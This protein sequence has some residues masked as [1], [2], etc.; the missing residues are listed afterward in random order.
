MANIT[1]VVDLIHPA[2]DEVSVITADTIWI[3]FDR[4]MDE[5]SINTGT[6]FLQGPDSNALSGPDLHLYNENL[7]DVSNDAD[8]LNSPGFTG[9]VPGTI[10]FQK[11]NNLSLASYT[12][13]DYSG[14]GTLW[15]T[16]AVFTP[17]DSLAP[18][19][20]YTVYLA[21]DEDTSADPETGIRERTVFDTQKGTNTG[22]GEASFS[23]GYIGLVTS[24]TFNIEFTTAGTRGVARFKWWKTSDPDILY[25]NIITDDGAIPLEDGVEITFDNGTYEVG[26]S[27]SVNVKKGNIFYGNL[28]WSFTTG[29]GSIQTVPAST[30][31]SIIGTAASSPITDSFEVSTVD[32]VHRATN[33]PLTANEIVFTFNNDIDT[34]TVT[35]ARVTVIGEPVNGDETL[36]A[37][38]TLAKDITVDGKTLTIRIR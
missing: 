5:I 24:D 31:T 14:E 2:S 6:F 20:E 21:G 9:I 36:L 25:S 4:E 28:I 29:S 3:L 17:T 10:T 33:Q 8:F 18:N 19:I 30:A 15:R 11:I 37:T 12:G 23:G 27:W 34:T 38:R 13:F 26:D 32:P 16:K 7:S 1:T 22:D 35:S